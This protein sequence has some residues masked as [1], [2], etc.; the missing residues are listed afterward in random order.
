MT[1]DEYRKDPCGAS[2]LSFWKTNL[3]AIPEDMA[4]LRE[5]AFDS[6]AFPGWKEEIFFK[7]IHGLSAVERPAIP[8]GTE[9]CMPALQELTDHINLCYEEA[10]ISPKEVDGWRKCPVYE[11]S[12]WIALREK[13]T[14]ALCASGIA[15]LDRAI[16]EGSLDWIQVS[17]SHRGKGMGAFLVR[18]LLFRMKG[19]ADFVTVSGRLQNPSQPQRL[20][21]GCGFSHPVLW[22]ILR[23]KDLRGK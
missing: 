12:L 9:L 4:V 18:E 7:M 2:A 22:H 3:V 1:Q 6:A 5:D 16:G 10:C 11:P 13:A 8:A 19:Q 17:P 21:L 14:G 20:Y 23:R 15:Q